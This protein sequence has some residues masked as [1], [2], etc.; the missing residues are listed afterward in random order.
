MKI[1]WFSPYAAVWDW[2]YQEF[3]IQKFLK[4]KK[5]EIKTI[6]CSNILKKNCNAIN[7]HHT[8][9]DKN[10]FKSEMICKRCISNDKFLRKKLDVPNYN[11]N[12][13]I[14]YRDKEKT[15]TILKRINKK[16]I[17]NYCYRNIPVG[18]I[19]MFEIILE[20][21]KN[22]LNLNNYEYYK[23]KNNLE[24]CINTIWPLKNK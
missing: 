3:I 24:N 10:K 1:L 17:I 2:K 13:W 11:L 22:N 18:K 6:S 14:N 12:D 9:I 7:A 15:K 20:F 21:K 5:L 8:N 19:A 23:L 16:N 4:V